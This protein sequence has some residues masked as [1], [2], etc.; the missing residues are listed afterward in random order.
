M[1]RRL[2]F[3]VGVT[4]LLAAC[5][6]TEE[7]TL[8]NLGDLDIKIDT[9]APILGARNKAMDSYWELMSTTPE[10]AQKAEA[11]RRLADLEMER[12]EERFQK[13]LEVL[14]QSQ[15]GGEVDQQALKNITYR[16]AIK[17]YEDALKVS[18]GGPQEVAILYQLSKAYDQAGDPEKAL[19]A[20]NRVL[21]IRPNAENRDE[22]QFRRGEILFDLRRFKQA[23]QAYSQTVAIGP[24]SGYYEKALS[25]RGWAAFKQGKFEAATGSFF[26][27]IDRKLRTP[28]GSMDTEGE[29]LSRGDNYEALPRRR[30]L[31]E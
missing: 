29:H 17:L 3:P 31:A 5:A 16:G 23:E 20:L 11:M 27:L 14:D 15:S 6:S 26:A 9:E 12:S 18:I 10:Q 25:K 13:Q 2:L 8:E 24:V 4:I 21:A 28:D 7:K 22:L 1:M 30:N 19:A